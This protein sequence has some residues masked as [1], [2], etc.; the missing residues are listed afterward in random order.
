TFLVT[1]V[2]VRIA[3]DA[4]LPRSLHISLGNRIALAYLTDMHGTICAACKA[5]LNL[6]LALPALQFAE[7]RLHIV[8]RP[9]F[10]SL[11]CP[12][13]I[14]LRDTAHIDHPVDQR[15]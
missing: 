13:V 15:R 9:A 8:P 11:C 6:L 1:R 10:C 3:R 4:S 7:I 14:V 12:T 2:V 5:A